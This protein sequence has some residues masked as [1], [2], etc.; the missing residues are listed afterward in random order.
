MAMDDLGLIKEGFLADMLLVAGDPTTNV[1]LLQ[2]KKNFTM[3]MIDGRYHKA[4]EKGFVENRFRPI[5]QE[6]FA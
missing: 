4:P 2:D 6:S 5:R 3:I 1:K